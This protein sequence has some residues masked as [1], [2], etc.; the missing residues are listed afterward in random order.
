MTYKAGEGSKALLTARFTTGT[1]GTTQFTGFIDVSDGVAF[2]YNGTSFGILYRSFGQQ[3]IRTLTVTAA[4][5]GAETATVTLNGVTKNV[6]LTNGTINATAQAI[7]SADYTTIGSGWLAYAVGATVV[8]LSDVAGSLN[9]TYSLTSTGTAAGTF[10]QSNAG[11]TPTDTWI[12]QNTWNVDVCNGSSTPAIPNTSNPSGINLV[13]TNLQVYKFQVQYLGAGNLFFFVENPTNGQLSPV[14]LI[15]RAGQNTTTT[16]GNVNLPFG[17]YVGNG[18]TA[19]NMTFA[20]ACAYGATEGVRLITGPSISATATKTGITTEVPILT[21]RNDLTFNSVPNTCAIVMS[22][23]NITNT[24]GNAL[25]VWRVV[26]NATLTGALFS[27]VDANTPMSQDSS[28]TA[29]SGGTVVV[30]YPQAQGTTSAR[31]FDPLATDAGRI[32]PGETLTFTLSTTGSAMVG[33]V[34]VDS[35]WNS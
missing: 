22:F 26:R 16:F 34:S 27:R 1:A 24:G 23:L 31:T 3:E 28:A 19:N 12:P 7:G 25:G 29:L 15:Q 10:V 14:H 4:A 11:V 18:A 32:F 30:S 5:T 9:G 21:I 13:P 17:G 6:A 35:R 2:G 8:F 20:S 33:A